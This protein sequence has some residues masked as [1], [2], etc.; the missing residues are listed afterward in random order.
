M[1]PNHRNRR[2]RAW[3]LILLGAIQMPASGLL[4]GCGVTVTKP[5]AP[6][7][8][9]DAEQRRATIEAESAEYNARRQR[10]ATEAEARR[11]AEETQAIDVRADWKEFVMSHYQDDVKDQLLSP[12]SARFENPPVLFASHC[13][14]ENYVAISAA[15]QV[16]A[17]NPFGALIRKSYFITWKQSGT[18]ATAGN[19]WGEPSVLI[20]DR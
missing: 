8:I 20:A 6:A 12:A 4:C 3:V 17:Q 10:E 19:G 2:R 16:D 18:P 5:Q 13:P 11:K 14:G 1:P 15:G 9:S 7:N